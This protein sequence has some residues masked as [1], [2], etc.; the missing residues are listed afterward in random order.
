MKSIVYLLIC[1]V[2][3][4]LF[5]AAPCRASV[6]H[7]DPGAVGTGNGE[8]WANAYTTISGALAASTSG[9]ELWARAA[10]YN[11]TAYIPDGFA[12]YG[13]FSGTEMLRDQ[14]DWTVNETIID[15]TG[16]GTSAVTCLNSTVLDGFTVRHG[17]ADKGGGVRFAGDGIVVANCR[18]DGNRAVNAGGGVFLAGDGSVLEDCTIEN[19]E[20]AN[21]G[22]VAYGEAVS[23][24]IVQNCVIANNHVAGWGGGVYGWGASLEDCI[25]TSNSGGTRGG[26]VYLQQSGTVRDCTVSLNT[27][28][29]GGG[30]YFTAATKISGCLIA[31][32]RADN[33]GGIY[34]LSGDFSEITHCTIVR[35]EATF[36]ASGLFREAGG[37]EPLPIK[38]SVFWNRGVELY[39]MQGPPPPVPLDV[40]YC[41]VQ[42]GWPG[43]GNIDACPEFVDPDGGD[44]RLADG[45]ACIDAGTDTG[46]PFN[47]TAPDIGAF[48]S[49]EGFTGGD[50]VHVPRTVHVAAGA[51]PG[52]EGSTWETALPSIQL[53]LDVSST[54]DEIW[55]TAGR[56]T[57]R[58]LLEPTVTLLGGFNGSETVRQ[59]R[60]WSANESIIDATE[61]GG[62]AVVAFDRSILDGVTITGGSA[63]Y[64]GG[65][66]LEEGSFALR[67]S[68]VRNNRADWGG[69]AYAGILSVLD[70][71]GCVFR[72]NRG[73]FADSRGIRTGG[74]FFIGDHFDIHCTVFVGNSGAGLFAEYHSSSTISSSLFARNNGG[75]VAIDATYPELLDIINCTV[76]SNTSDTGDPGVRVNWPGPRIENSIIWNGDDD[77]LGFL[78][79][80]YSCIAG[81]LSPG[82]VKIDDP[83]FVNPDGDDWRLQEESPLVD[84]GNPDPAYNDA[85]LPPGRGSLRNDMG[86][87][88]GPGNCD[89]PVGW[90]FPESPLGD[91]NGDGVVDKEDLFLF[92]RQWR[93][94]IGP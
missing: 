52:G 55:V 71:T 79:L 88:G 43:E 32:N 45:S 3:L 21:G 23:G 59:D 46:R 51:A 75:G 7:I 47:G 91:M 13:G 42:C 9:D 72:E 81:W 26:G 58:I 11:E 31:G 83:M 61:L 74:L 65:I 56:Y 66:Y 24:P 40:Q 27:A 86:A 84:A 89:T 22:G 28:D 69:G 54:S 67:N 49:P 17:E 16:Q 25:I 50:G 41:A 38:N 57:E 90:G 44:W 80:H 63:E 77:T 36:W 12:L 85:C 76:V 92:M 64:G 14:R 33:G 68:T 82:I 20:A 18:I 30:I 8:N 6:I 29:E 37:G 73:E 94:T 70:A 15:A 19:N 34:S 78:D 53:A 10:I 35:N 4:C 93:R 2:I 39:A 48:E 87:Y 1:T 62:S 5:G 60:D